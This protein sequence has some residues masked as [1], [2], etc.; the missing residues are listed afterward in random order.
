MRSDDVLGLVELPFDYRQTTPSP[1]NK[2]PVTEAQ[3]DT[4]AGVIFLQ[5]VNTKREGAV[6][7]LISRSDKAFGQPSLLALRAEDATSVEA[8][9][10]ALVRLFCRNTA[11][12]AEFY[13][14]PET[15]SSTEVAQGETSYV[16][17]ETAFIP[18]AGAV[19][20]PDLFR[21]LVTAATDHSPPTDI[22]HKATVEL[23]KRVKQRAQADGPQQPIPG[24]FPKPE[25]AREATPPLAGASAA[26]DDAMAVDGS[27]APSSPPQPIIGTGDALVVE[28]APAACKRFFDQDNDRSN[29][30][31]E[32]VDPDIKDDV[33]ANKTRSLSLDSCLT[34]FCQPE[35]LGED[36]P[37]R[38]PGPSAG[39]RLQRRY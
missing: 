19:P 32:Q 34:D 5:V 15:P 37:W 20:V 3:R 14:L 22:L 31:A 4:E 13:D 16:D 7:S 25:E 9:Y 36:N 1:R 11:L 23:S 27:S 18:P 8:V 30:F 17:G 6:T 26:A 12:A 29:L 28:W 35:R 38:C 21:I 2:Q 33:I 39:L 24:A 10:A